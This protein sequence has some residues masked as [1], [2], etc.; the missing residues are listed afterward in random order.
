MSQPI[1]WKERCN[2]KGNQNISAIGW[3]LPVLVR[4]CRFSAGAGRA[5]RCIQREAVPPNVILEHQDELKLS[6]AQ[7]SAIR[8]AVVEVQANV[9]EHEW[10][11]REAY[12]RAMTNLDESPV[13]EDKVL[14]NIE[15]VL[16]AENQVK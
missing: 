3:I 1:H 4:I 8:A 7:F 13:D 6:E 2:E 12:Q 11:L 10:D 5:E 9:A 16:Q 14:K 15:A